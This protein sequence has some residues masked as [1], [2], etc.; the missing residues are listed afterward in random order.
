MVIGRES[1]RDSFL[2]LGIM[3]LN[4]V[5]TD[6][7]TNKCMEIILFKVLRAKQM[8]IKHYDSIKSRLQ[9]DNFL[10]EGHN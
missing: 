5:V 4:I 1:Q 10:E 8:A 2:I 7:Q 9:L 6:R 3:T